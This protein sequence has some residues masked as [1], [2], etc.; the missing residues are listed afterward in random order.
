MVFGGNEKREQ[1]EALFLAPGFFAT[2]PVSFF[3]SSESVLFSLVLLFL[4]RLLLGASLS[5]SSLPSDIRAVFGLAVE[6]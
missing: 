3:L 5:S 2:L 6:K 4:S 1:R